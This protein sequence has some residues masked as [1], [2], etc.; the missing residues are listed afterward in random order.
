MSE[1][2][3]DVKEI[4]SALLVSQIA[5]YEVLTDVITGGLPIQEAQRI[6]KDHIFALKAVKAKYYGS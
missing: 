4:L 2:N 1:V 3:Q 6:S 5:A